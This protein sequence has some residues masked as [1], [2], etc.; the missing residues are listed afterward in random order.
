M[1]QALVEGIQ[2]GGSPGQQRGGFGR[3]PLL[4]PMT[5]GEDR[6]GMATKLGWELVALDVEVEADSY[7]CPAVLGAGL[8]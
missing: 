7:Y 4:D 8:Y 2:E 5:V 6:G 1:V 3:P